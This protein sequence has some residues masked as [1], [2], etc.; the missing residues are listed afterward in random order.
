MPI[1]KCVCWLQVTLQGRYKRAFCA[2]L[3][4]GRR[5]C[6]WINAFQSLNL[7][8]ALP[9]SL[10]DADSSRSIVMLSH[11]CLSSLSL[12]LLLLISSL[13]CTME[14]LKVGGGQTENEVDC[15]INWEI[16]ERGYCLFSMQFMQTM[17]DFLLRKTIAN[18]Q[19]QSRRQRRETIAH[20]KRAS[21]LSEIVILMRRE[22]KNEK[23]NQHHILFVSSIFSGRTREPSKTIVRYL[24][25]FDRRS[26]ISVFNW[27]NRLFRELYHRPAIFSRVRIFSCVS[28][29]P[30]LIFCSFSLV[31]V[32]G[33]CG[34]VGTRC[35]SHIFSLLRDWISFERESIPAG[36]SGNIRNDSLY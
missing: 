4:A 12:V 33:G 14:S 17:C 19:H 35:D 24:L 11:A 3:L 15:V 25:P 16:T 5:C 22:K 20:Q 26:A 2:A 21:L 18:R 29:L 30:L 31:C 34:V 10:S 32:C 13:W 27:C 6:C 1:E 23:K 7:L 8:L 9:A 28:W 36:F